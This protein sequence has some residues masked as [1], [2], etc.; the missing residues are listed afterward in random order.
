MEYLPSQARTSEPLADFGRSPN[1]ETHSFF[2]G[3]SQPP[4]QID[5]GSEE[6]RTHDS[7][8][9]WLPGNLEPLDWECVDFSVAALPF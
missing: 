2:S 6:T 4:L 9:S 5:N 7:I 8:D 3:V 1:I